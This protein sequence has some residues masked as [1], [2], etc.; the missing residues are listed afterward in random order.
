MQQ[1]A[2]HQ[3]SHFYRGKALIKCGPDA[4]PSEV[5]LRSHRG[6]QPLLKFRDN[7]HNLTL[8]GGSGPRHAEQ[9]ALSSH[10]YFPQAVLFYGGRQSRSGQGLPSGDL[11]HNVSC[12]A[13]ARTLSREFFKALFSMRDFP[14]PVSSVVY[15]D[16]VGKQKNPVGSMKLALI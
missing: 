15:Q 7:Y 6:I 5:A 3:P 13:V 12:A 1:W 14:L 16:P 2:S 9:R 11:L 8:S 10:L 4:K